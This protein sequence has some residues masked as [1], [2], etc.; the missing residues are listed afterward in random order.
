MRDR[1]HLPQPLAAL[2]E[3]VARAFAEDGHELYLV[4]GVVRDLLLGAP[5]GTDLD[6]ASDALPE[7]ARSALARLRPDGMYDVGKRFGTMGAVFGG[8]RVEVTT[9]RAEAYAAGSR[10]PD[11]AFQG[12]LDDDLARRDFTINAIAAEP[13]GGQ[14]VDPLGGRQDL[15]RQRLRAVGEPSERFLDDPL[16]LLRA[17]RFASR[18]HFELDPPTAS[19]VRATAE[20]LASISRER[21][22]DELDKIVAG[23]APARGIALL[24]ELGLAAHTLPE[25][26]ALRGMRQ[27]TGRHKDVF[28][29]TLQVLDRTPPRLALRWAALLHDVAKPRTLSMTANGEVHFFGHDALGARVT[30]RILTELHQPHELVE[31]ASRLVGMHLRANAYDASWTDGAVRR[32]VREVGEDLLED[33]LALSR[34]DVT[35]GRADRRLAI[36]GRVA[37]L[38]QRILALSAEEDIARLD[39]PLDGNALMA[40]FERGPG[41][42]IRPIKDRLRELV[43]DGELAED[44]QATATAIARQLYAE[45]TDQA[46]ETA[47]LR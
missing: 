17:V 47:R 42:W 34:A 24:C 44:D 4:G 5:L 15:E 6:F 1:I 41:P 16:R 9:Y 37:E 13:L 10:K 25:L 35:T 40:L 11:V 39:S 22:R 43:I 45:V 31:R 23:A 21:V 33:V 30:R 20:A 19:A 36:A 28:T 8:V 12:R 29:H 3:R 38:E 46:H 7:A 2:A 27:E 26:L 32:F 14:L 18:L